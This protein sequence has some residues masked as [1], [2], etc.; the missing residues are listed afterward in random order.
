[1]HNLLLLDWLFGSW[2]S[3]CAQSTWQ[4]VVGCPSLLAEAAPS[5][6]DIPPGV[7]HAIVNETGDR[8]RE[9][10]RRKCIDFLDYH[11][12][13]VRSRFAR[14]ESKSCRWLLANDIVWFDQYCPIN[15]PDRSQGNLF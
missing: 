14:A 12:H 10:H 8:V 9:S 5:D 6:A 11:T 15:K 4:T 3:S 7:S 13:A 1:M 2:K